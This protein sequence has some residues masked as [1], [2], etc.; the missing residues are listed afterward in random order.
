METRILV[1]D[2]ISISLEKRTKTDKKKNLKSIVS[3]EKPTSSSRDP[4]DHSSS[5]K[6]YSSED[7]NY[8]ST[9]SDDETEKNGGKYGK[10]SEFDYVSVKVNERV[11][12]GTI[13][14]P[15]EGDIQVFFIHGDEDS[16]NSRKEDENVSINIFVPKNGNLKIMDT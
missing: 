4:E 3:S 6:S 15:N 11:E 10:S 16:E 14:H 9:D 1:P 7:K 12:K 2:C 8:S 13:L 5:E